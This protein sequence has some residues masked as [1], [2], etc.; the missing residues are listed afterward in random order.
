[1]QIIR[2]DGVFSKATPP[3]PLPKMKEFYKTQ[4][5]VVSA[6]MATPLLGASNY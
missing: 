6:V 5:K 1:M 2:Y 3:A 4:V